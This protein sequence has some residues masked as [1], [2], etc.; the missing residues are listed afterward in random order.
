[1]KLL[2]Q[3][4]REEPGLVLAVLRVTKKYVKL[5]NPSEHQGMKWKNYCGYMAK[6]K[7]FA[8]PTGRNN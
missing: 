4:L 3:Q 2:V 8:S 6:L 5:N 7:L 1:M